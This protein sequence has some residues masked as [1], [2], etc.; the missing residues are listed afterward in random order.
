[1]HWMTLVL[2]TQP[3]QDLIEEAVLRFKEK[4]ELNPCQAMVN[5]GWGVDGDTISGI[6]VTHGEVPYTNMVMIR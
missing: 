3:L 5:K 2:D 6:K 1:M 4:Y